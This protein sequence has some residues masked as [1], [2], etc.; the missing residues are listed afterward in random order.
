MCVL[1]TC[2][3]ISTNQHIA[4][5][6][7]GKLCQSLIYCQKTNC[8][9]LDDG[10]QALEIDVYVWTVSDPGTQSA[11]S[12]D[13]GHTGARPAHWSSDGGPKYVAHVRLTSLIGF[14]A[15]AYMATTCFATAFLELILST[16]LNGSLQN[17][18]NT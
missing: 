8:D 15:A 2:E 9:G 17:F 18:F 12:R 5:H 14:V 10:S 13:G 16:P 7:C 1:Y 4:S 6:C 11:K 3:C